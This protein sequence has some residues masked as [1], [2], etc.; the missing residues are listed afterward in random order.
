MEENKNLNSQL[1]AET[2]AQNEPEV[3]KEKKAKAPRIRKPKAEKPKKIK[4]QALLKKGS[5]SLALT[6][7]VIAAV[8][9][10]N[11]LVGAL[12]SRFVLEFDMTADKVSSINEK[13]AEYIKS[14][15]DEIEVILCADEE[16][17][18]GGYMQ[19]YAQAYNVNDSNADSYYQQTVK[20]IKRY[21]DYN[22]N[23]KVKF[24]D[25]QS[26]EF[27]AIASEYSNDNLSYG[28]IVVSSQKD[29]VKRHKVLTYTDIYELTEDSTYAAY[30]YS[31]STVSG[32]KIETA[33]T[34]AIDY[35]TS[36]ES[37]KIAVYTG[38]SSKD[39]TADYLK[40]LRD[41]N[42]EVTA[43]ED[44]LIAEIP[45]EYDAILIAAPSIDFVGSEID[46]I[47]EFLDND[48][49]YGKGLLF[50]AD[51]T[52]PYLPNLYEFLSDWGIVVED[53]VLY[54]TTSAN[55]ISGNP[56]ALGSYPEGDDDITKGAKIVI[57]DNNVPLTAAFEEEGYLE[58]KTLISS[59][60]STIAAP[61]G[62]TAGWTGADDYEK[63]S[64]ATVL[65]SKL[66]KYDEDNNVI[67]SYI[68]AFG[69]TD[70]L[71]SQYN[72][73][74]SV[75]NKEMT[76]AAAERAVGADTS[77]VYFISKT[78]GSESFTPIESTTAIMRVLFIFVIPIAI[79]G[80]GIYVY[81][82]RRNA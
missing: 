34:G 58:V 38:H 54:E 1:E 55:H 52:A 2:D 62:T 70:F 48:G 41:N 47:S 29:G 81:I 51:V 5:Y 23:I 72:E 75:F 73:Q 13:N 57:T 64:Y 19:Y 14:I 59:L 69:S 35:V 46:A 42:Y 15:E 44:M 63:K 79:I 9:A 32:N 67:S 74:S 77:D 18:G 25:T 76:L 30:G 49:N 37:K 28:D 68:L 22:K 36:S 7:I 21:N 80:A 12:S 45:S 65:Q 71:S 53:A 24:M 61:K 60:E 56:L 17:Y 3:K 33:L 11:I 39:Y 26:D 40:L 8:I 16:G 4:N 66:Y 20:L 82:K 31:I 43:I 78:I 6:A 27:V 10:L 50:F